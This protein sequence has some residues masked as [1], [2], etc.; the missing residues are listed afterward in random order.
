MAHEIT[1]PRLHVM[2]IDFPVPVHPLRIPNVRAQ[3]A[4]GSSVIDLRFLR[5]AGMLR[6]MVPVREGTD[7]VKLRTLTGSAAKVYGKVPV[8]FDAPRARV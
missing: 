3:F 6:K 1:D 7:R 5:M 2:S 4:T 8:K